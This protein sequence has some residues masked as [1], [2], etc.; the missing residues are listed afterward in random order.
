MYGVWA[1]KRRSSLASTSTS[2][3]ASPRHPGAPARRGGNEAV[4]GLV[5][6]GAEGE[7][8]EGQVGEEVEG[9]DLPVRVRD[10]R[11]DLGA[12]V[13]EDEHVRDLGPRAERRGALGPEV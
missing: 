11:A 1:S 6:P 9:V 7:L 5:E 4:V 3:N 8:A 13:L 12:A 2:R 10:R